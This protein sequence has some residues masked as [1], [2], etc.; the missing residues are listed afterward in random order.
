MQ[1]SAARSWF[2][3]A[4]IVGEPAI[5]E[6]YPPRRH[7]PRKKFRHAKRYY[8]KLSRWAEELDID[9]GCYD[10]DH[11]HLA[12]SIGDGDR[13]WKERRRHLAVLLSLLRRLTA[14]ERSRQV[15]VQVW[16]QIYPLGSWEDSIWLNSAHPGKNP[17][18]YR[19]EGVSW[20]ESVPERLQDFFSDGVLQFGRRDDGRTIFYA[21]AMPAP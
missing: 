12:G 2:G 9:D 16:A 7:P 14:K 21:R 15:P 4:A 11:Y 20:N 6:F 13:N 8:R 17:F 3:P 5:F 1:S 19:F 18:P 10:F